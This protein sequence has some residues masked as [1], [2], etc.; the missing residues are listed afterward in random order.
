MQVEKKNIAEL[1]Q[2]TYFNTS[3]SLSETLEKAIP[4]ESQVY[5]IVD[6]ARNNEIY[7]YLHTYEPDYCCLYWG[8]LEKKLATVAPY[9]VKLEKN[10]YFTQWLLNNSYGDHQFILLRSTYT[11]EALTE[12]FMQYIMVTLPTE[13]SSQLEKQKQALFAFYDPRV[14]VSWIPKLRKQDAHDFFQLLDLIICE[15]PKNIEE[16]I[17]Y[18][19]GEDKWYIKNMFLKDLINKEHT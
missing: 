13:D 14:F 10:D 17:L 19:V 12:H 16:L 7:H 15:N 11:L 2:A 3:Q 5:A 18:Q 8:L 9:L 1:L 4:E 6:S